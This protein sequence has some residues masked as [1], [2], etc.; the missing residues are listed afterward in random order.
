MFAHFASPAS[1]SYSGSR[2]EGVRTAPRP[3]LLGAYETTVFLFVILI[4]PILV[5]IF[6]ADLEEEVNSM[7]TTFPDDDKTGSCL[8]TGT[9]KNNTKGA[10]EVRKMGRK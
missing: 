8:L 10:S 5:D 9:Q 7:L 6:I 1:T 2:A 4:R 3:S